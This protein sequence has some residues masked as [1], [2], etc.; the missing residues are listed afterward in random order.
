MHLND[1]VGRTIPFICHH[2]E[3]ASAM[4]A[5]GYA[6]TLG[7]LAVVVVTT[8]PGGTNTITGVLGQWT[9]SVPVLYISGQVKQSTTVAS[10]PDIK[11][12]QLGDQEADII[13]LVKPI[14][15][16]AEV[17]TKAEDT[18]R[19]LHNAISS[20]LFGRPGPVWLDVPMDV[21][22]AFFDESIISTS[23]APQ[24][25]AFD[26]HLAS[27]G[28]E[29]VRNLIMSSQRPVF[30]CGHGI[31]I[32]RALPIFEKITTCLRMPLLTTFNGFDIVASDNPLSVGRI[33][34]IGNRAGNFALQNADLVLS[35][36]SRNNIRQISYNWDN[37]A[38]GAKKVVVDIDEAELSKPT[39]KPDI[40]VHCDAKYFLERLYA[41][42]ETETLPDW[43]MW[44]AW[45]IE[46]KY[47]YPTVLTDY[48]KQTGS[49]HP[50][51]FMQALSELLDENAIVVTGNGTASVAYFQSAVVKKEQRIIWNS[52]CASMGYDVPAAIGASLA[53]GGKKV[54]CLAGD[55]SIQMNIQELATIR[56]YNL[57][58]CIFVLNNAGYSS[59]KQSQ[60]NAFGRRFGCDRCTGVGL[61]DIVPIARAYGFDTD[62]I[63]SHADMRDKIMH[64]LQSTAPYLCEVKLPADYFFAPKV[65]SERLP[66]GRFI[67]KPLDDMYPF[68]ER[69]E[70]ENNRYST[71][72]SRQPHAR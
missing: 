43:S 54:V 72:D 3:Q 50:Y 37:F 25:N 34:T 44:L 36:G 9:D 33:G 39:L 29:K 2:H 41:T 27:N 52:G 14:T 15:K 23:L 38:Q 42:L 16:F 31:R 19:L 47:R 51:V 5:E 11:L 1:A 13:S 45:C 21:Q 10:C 30:V 60:D 61:P 40:A 46:K 67:S 8:G 69:S 57:P 28:I 35:V 24:Q 26:I 56:H 18:P 12:R 55:G 4:A 65:A 70:Y 32:A 7:S 71:L 59:I 22:G 49:V 6:R 68:L 64:S 53:S 63:A 62:S 66:D 17:I 48:F 20:A 58:I